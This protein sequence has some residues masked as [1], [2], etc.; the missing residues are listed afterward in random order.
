MRKLEELLSL[1]INEDHNID[2]DLGTNDDGDWILSYRGVDTD[3]TSMLDPNWI[4]KELKNNKKEASAAIYFSG[5]VKKGKKSNDRMQPD[6]EDEI[7]VSSASL[8]IEGHKPI[9]LSDHLDKFPIKLR[10]DMEDL[11]LSND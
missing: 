4:S 8:E 10:D 2:V 1:L 9:D 5:S 11:L 6:D 3:I 7:D